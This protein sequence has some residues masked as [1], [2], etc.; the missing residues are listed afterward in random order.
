MYKIY[1]HQRGQVSLI[2]NKKWKLMMFFF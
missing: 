2:P 1:P